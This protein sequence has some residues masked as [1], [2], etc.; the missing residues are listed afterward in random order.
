MPTNANMIKRAT[1]ASLVITYFWVVFEIFWKKNLY[2]IILRIILIFS[3][4]YAI[5][6]VFQY[7]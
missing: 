7:I 2:N 4:K 3:Q 1:I 5:F 6:K